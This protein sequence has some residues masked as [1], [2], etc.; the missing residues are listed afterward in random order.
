MEMTNVEN[1][2]SNEIR[3]AD[4]TNGVVHVG[5]RSSKVTSRKSIAIHIRCIRAIRRIH[6]FLS[7]RTTVV[8]VHVA[9]DC[10]R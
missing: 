2:M 9:V 6:G 3:K 5:V 7:Y 8:A 10:R 1:Q 4:M